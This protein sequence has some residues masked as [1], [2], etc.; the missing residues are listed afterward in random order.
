MGRSGLGG[1]L[2]HLR[3][4][5]APAACEQSDG[6]LLSAYCSSQD[7]SAFAA[8]V[9][10]HGPLVQMVCGRILRRTEDREDAFQATFLVLARDAASLRARESIAGWLHGVAR[11]ISLTVC[12][13]AVRRHKY[14][15]QA[16][17]RAAS[18][19]AWEAA[20]R[21]VQVV[22]DEEIQR[23]PSKYREPF[24]LCCLEGQSRS[25]A[26]A[27]LGLKEGTVGSRLTEARR[28][29]RQRLAHRGVELN[30]VLGTTAIAVPHA[31][32][33]VTLTANLAN[34]AAQLAAGQRLASG[35][36]P[37][38]ILSLVQGVPKAMCLTKAKLGTLLLLAVGLLGGGA[39]AIAYHAPP[40]IEVR[41]PANG[42][43][44]R[45][46]AA[47]AK[48]ETVLWKKQ[49]D[50]ELDGWL[51]FALVYSPDGQALVVGGSDGKVAAFD[52]RTPAETWKADVGGK[53]PAVAY[54]A[55]GKSI[56]AT[57]PDGVRFLDAATGKAGDSLEEKGIGAVA[58]GVFPDV[59]FF[60]GKNQRLTSH[61]VV[62]ASAQR[63]VVKTWT[64]SG[65]P[66]TIN[67]DT[68][69]PT[70][71]AD[72][73]AVPLA[74]DPQGKC[75]IVRGP[76]DR[77]SGK[78]V[79]WA[80]VAGDSGS[81]S[82]GN[83]LLTGHHEAVVISAAWS[84]N[85]KIAVTGDASGRVIVWDGKTLREVDRFE[86]G[87]RVAALAVSPH[88]DYLAAAVVGKRAEY[89]AWETTKTPKNKPLHVDAWDF[90]DTS[91]ASLAFSP[92]GRQLAGCALNPDWLNRLG[93]LMGH[94]HLWNAPAGANRPGPQN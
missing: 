78:N 44:S 68:S 17:P 83:R 51:P 87:G 94:V 3:G 88:A 48:G 73:S 35:L 81:E 18:N 90:G 41:Q 1:V 12:R 15:E 71:R 30:A 46:A 86:L 4:L 61:K 6:E 91:Y 22:L 34:V 67:L 82:P 75:V 89:Y 60:A 16:M 32:V 14:E 38:R 79:L 52:P 45:S 70:T 58:I 62:F 49:K 2:C 11:H 42:N 59:T 5:V 53:F 20:W 47:P 28:K 10:R 13:A 65:A 72:P 64:G 39:G 19:P 26:A 55:D 85:G 9:K 66:G 80:W 54:S 8:L 74:V 29:L 56:L 27:R 69:N 33:P 50:L 84:R 40:E 25:E 93:E 37:A 57:F 63:C 21:E 7:Q 43:A 92:D 31:H 23:L 24:V 76:I 77:K 36:V